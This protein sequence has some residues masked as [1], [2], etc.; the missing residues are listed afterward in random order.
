MMDLGGG[1]VLGR[2]TVSGLDWRIWHPV[3]L[4]LLATWLG[5]PSVSKAETLVRLQEEVK[6]GACSRVQIELKADGFFQRGLPPGEATEGAKLPKPLSLDVKTRLVFLE[7]V[8]RV[9]PAGSGRIERSARLVSQAASAINGEIR[10]SQAVLRR[11]VSR[12]IAERTEKDS[13]EPV[14]VVSPAGPLSRSELE[15]VQGVGDPLSLA[16]LLPSEPVATGKSWKLGDSA[17]KAVS[18]YDVVTANRLAATLESADAKSARVHIKGEVEGSVLGGSGK[19]SCD[20]FY[21][22]D[23]RAGWI[24]RL[25][26]N[27][28]ESRQAGL[29]EAGLDVK[30]TVTVTRREIEPPTELGDPS[31]GDLT[32][33]VSPE[34]RLLSLS[35]PDGKA[36]LLH[37]RRWHT[38][39]D[40]A[41]MVVLKRVEGGRVIGQ[42][43]LTI[44]PKVAKGKHQDPAQ[45]RDDIRRALGRRFVEFVGAGEV[46]GDPTGGF[47]YKVGV[48]G[49]EG[50][51]NLLWSYYL[52][53]SPEGDQLLA[54]FTLAEDQFEAFG[55]QDLVMIGSLQWV[56]SQPAPTTAR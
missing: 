55:D 48:R 15:L 30:S 3:L 42:C 32:G 18:S 46:D 33:P 19:I 29:V 23:R 11:E 5:Q 39:W 36:V 22:F 13:D 6:E 38:T 12:L 21:T 28:K 51:V 44:G 37:D 16:D 31:I 54:T 9:Q 26:L 40:D 47:R 34:R 52:L 20:G 14:T 10:P 24:D 53:A 17:A 43:N 49:R 27:R 45:F 1:D 7:R 35:S 41:R 2:R 8:I 56:P 4:V 25:E 50:N